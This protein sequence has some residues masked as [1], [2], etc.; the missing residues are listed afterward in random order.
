MK[1]IVKDESEN[2]IVKIENSDD[3]HNNRGIIGFETWG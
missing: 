3:T 1:L 2:T